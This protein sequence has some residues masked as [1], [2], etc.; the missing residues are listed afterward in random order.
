MRIFYDI[1]IGLYYLAALMISPWNRKAKQWIGGRRGWRKPLEKAFQPGD[2]VV[3]VH[4][5]SLGE[6]EQGRPVIETLKERCPDQK[7]LLSFFS[8]SGY[9]KR[10][11]Y[12][13]ADHVMYLP[14]D[15]ARNARKLIDSL[16]LEMVLFIKYEFWFH[17]LTRL[18]KKG[19]PVYLVSGIFRPDQVFFR[20]YGGW[21]R[22]FLDTFTHIFVQQEPSLRLLKE[23]GFDRVSVAG[24][25]R[26]DRVM[27]L[28]QSGYSNPAM[29]S[30]AAHARVIVAGSTWEPDE[31]LLE[32]AYHELPLDL[33]WI[34][35]PH[36]LSAGHL[37]KL[38]KRFPGSILF[39]L[40]GSE[41][42]PETRVVIVDTIGHLSQLYRYGTLAY[43][44]GGFGKGIHNILEAATFG[45]PVLFGPNFRKFSEA[46][47]LSERGGAFIVSG[48]TELLSTVH[49]QLGN[50]N[51]LKTTSE[52]ASNYVSERLGATSKIVQK[53]CK[54]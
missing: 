20:W 47:E 54:K 43:I 50:P 2:R 42:P 39:T 13:L 14:L 1:G 31:Q 24:D 52:I 25:T 17:F 5:A 33:K 18:G 40:S 32:E 38:Q 53:V 11:D 10:K 28:A 51:L 45:L 49:Q 12:P 41:I 37:E 6:F 3:W 48:R 44:G 19:V 35:A 9:E 8:P 15:T 7:I 4:C 21:Y 26:F 36:E 29:E 30:F 46:V 34:I 23:H 16:S 22:R 27:Q